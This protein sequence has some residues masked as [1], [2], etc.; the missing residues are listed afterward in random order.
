MFGDKDKIQTSA[1]KASF[2]KMFL[3]GFNPF[4]NS[5]VSIS[6]SDWDR[7]VQEFDDDPV[8][9]NRFRIAIKGGGLNQ[10]EVNLDRYG[11]RLMNGELSYLDTMPFIISGA[12]VLRYPVRIETSDVG[13]YIDEL[14]MSGLRT[15]AGQLRLLSAVTLFSGS[16]LAAFRG[17]FLGLTTSRGGM[18]D[19]FRFGLAEKVDVFAPEFENYLSQFGPTLKPSIPFKVY[20]CIIRPSYE[21]LFV[22]GASKG[23]AGLSVRAPLIS[24]LA[25]YGAGF[26]NTSVRHRKQ[27]LQ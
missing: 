24:Y 21:Q 6:Q 9:L 11:D 23:E 12:A 13:D 25:L 15:S 22:S 2:G 14:R 4:D 27:P 16:S 20:D 3:N 1:P 17:A 8:K 26:T 10:E 18:V 7:I 19:S 5:A